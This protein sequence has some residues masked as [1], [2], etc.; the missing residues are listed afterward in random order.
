M[1][2]VA[3]ATPVDLETELK[4]AE[5]Q[6]QQMQ[7]RADSIMLHF[8]ASQKAMAEELE[9]E[10]SLHHSHLSERL[11]ERREHRKKMRKSSSAS[12]GHLDPKIQDLLTKLDT[13]VPLEQQIA[14]LM[15]SLQNL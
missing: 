15:S 8:V 1:E 6:A 4:I 12:H 11:K 7:D 14:S 5:S 3:L 10:T 13:S 2:A 9:R